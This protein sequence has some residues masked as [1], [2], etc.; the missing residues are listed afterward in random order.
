MTE[1]NSREDT[2][3]NDLKHVHLATI[4]LGA[5]NQSWRLHGIFATNNIRFI[6]TSRQ[7]RNLFRVNLQLA[8]KNFS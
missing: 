1:S 7:E 8:P 2:L 5:I 4:R 3:F 6:A